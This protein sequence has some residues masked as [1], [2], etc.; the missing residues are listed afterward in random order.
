MKLSNLKIHRYRSIRDEDIRLT[1]LNLF[2]GVNASGKS[3][4]LDALRFL[5][6]GFQA[7]DFRGP[8]FSRG[9]IIHLAWKGEEAHRVELTIDL[10]EDGKRYEWVVR[11]TREG[12]DFSVQERV[13]ELRPNAPPSHLL[14]SENGVGWWWSGEKGDVVN[15]SQ[16]RT[17]CALAAAAADAS[18]PARV[19]AEFVSR[20]G[21]FDPSPFLLRRGWVGLESPKFDPYGRNLADVLFAIKESNPQVFE[22]IVS[23][24]QSVLGLPMAIELREPRDADDRMHFVQQEPGLRFSVHQIG[25][26]SGTLRMLALLTALLGE[27]GSNIIGIEEPE[28]YVHPTALA[29]F[30]EY[31]LKARDRIQ[32]VVTTHSPFLLDL[33]N[34]PDAVCVVRRT[35]DNGTQV[36]REDNAEAVRQALDASGFG[37]GE[38]YETKGF[39]S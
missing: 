16:G 2:I 14:E 38:F 19:V 35:A 32:L 10:E 29:S 12:Y 24:T 7:R 9:G 20:W 6:E 33:L 36:T 34:E 25:A 3:T 30:A 23:A 8:V 11:L 26:S 27:A 17:G 22:E 5:H 4:I 15:L 39:G 31:L 13:S 21:F 37:L 28:N 18:F 1:D